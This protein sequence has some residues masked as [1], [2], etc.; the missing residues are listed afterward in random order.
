MDIK[1]V[2]EESFEIYAGMT[3]QKRAIVDAR[4]CLK[5]SARLS[6]YSQYI[7]KL[8][9]N[10]P[11]EKSSVSVA[12]A[13]KHFYPYGDAG[14]YSMLARLGKPFAM[15]Y[16]LEDFQGSTGDI[17]EDDNQA[18]MRYTNMRLS[19]IAMSLFK[20]VEKDSIDKW[21]PSYTGKEYYP[22]VLPSKGYYNICNG[23][24]GI[25]TALSSSIPQFNLKEVNSA[26]IKLLWNP[27]IDF[28]E[29]YCAPDFCTGGNILN[30]SEIKESLKNG[31]GKACK[32][33]ANAEW[34]EKDNSFV[35]T[36]IPYGVYTT[37]VAEQLLKL[38][39][40][41]KNPGILNLWD[42][43]TNS[44]YIKVQLEKNSDKQNALNVI[45]KET[46]LQYHYGINMIMLDKGKVPKVFSWKEALQA[47]LD[48]EKEVYIRS[49]I[50]D[51][52][53]ILD[54][55]HIL[56]ALIKAVNDI[57]T[58]IN[59]IRKS[60]NTEEAEKELMKYFDIDQVQS[61]AIL[62]IK[63]SKLTHL[64]VE[65]LLSEQSKLIKERD[66]IDSILND[67]ILLKKEIENGL[68]E[69]ANTFGDS[70]RT[71][72]YDLYR[73]EDEVKEEIIYFDN[74]GYGYNKE[75]ANSVGVVIS[76]TEYFCVTK[77]G[78]VYRSQIIP[79]RKKLIFKL[80]KG[81]SVLKV[82]PLNNDEYLTFIDDN[83]HFRCKEIKTLNKTKTSLPLTNLQFVGISPERVSKTNYKEIFK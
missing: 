51:K 61:K 14:L 73:E 34:I 6:I 24:M 82:F 4:D 36:N 47:H 75:I 11:Y 46:S 32:M 12:S 28:E 10:K 49:F 13:M 74:E 78:M 39:N 70:R 21:Y 40:S 68:M 31:N 65:I 25:A 69:I 79:K 26:L 67:E 72:I 53:K 30:E 54:R 23:T 76:G 48:H 58:V 59:I 56:E 63:L 7:D 43:S 38:K 8:Y 18:A 29:I 45:F 44:S 2:L 20:D 16:K 5:P 19:K 55:L 52:N 41:E 42:Q 27:D 62:N 60:N 15:R 81:D 33:R 9:P 1:K 37:T 80:D 77:N 64:E 66:R 3:I 50:Y 17:T 71:K 35:F 22:S 57:D 83:K